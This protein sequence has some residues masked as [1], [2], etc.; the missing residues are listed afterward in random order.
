MEYIENE[1]RLDKDTFYFTL[2]LPGTH[3]K[4]GGPTN[5]EKCD[6]FGVC[7]GGYLFNFPKPVIITHFIY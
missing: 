1:K 7:Q 5:C 4:E 6:D 2:C 3:L